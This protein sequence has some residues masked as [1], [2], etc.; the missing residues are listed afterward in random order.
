MCFKLLFSCSTSYVNNKN[1]QKFSNPGQENIVLPLRL[2]LC[3]LTLV[4]SWSS[5]FCSLFCYLMKRQHSELSATQP[6]SSC[7]TRLRKWKLSNH[8]LYAI[9]VFAIHLLDL[10]EE[11][12]KEYL[13]KSDLKILYFLFTNSLIKQNLER[14]K[15]K[16]RKWDSNYILP[17]RQ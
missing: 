9:F 17:K 6:V 8:A 3:V 2:L 1:I 5:E 14:R 13:L 15:V 10:E 16:E 11:S 12:I 7:T 4:T